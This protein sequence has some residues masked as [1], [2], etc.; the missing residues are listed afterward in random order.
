MQE[1]IDIAHDFT[2]LLNKNIFKNATFSIF[3][4]F[5]IVIIICDHRLNILICM[6]E[7]SLRYII[8]YRHIQKKISAFR[9][10]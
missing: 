10:T 7:K 8:T 2:E 6:K 4:R 3:Y 1:A 5:C 9:N